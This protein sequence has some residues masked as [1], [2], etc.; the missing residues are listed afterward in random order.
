MDDSRGSRVAEIRG[1]PNAGTMVLPGE[2]DPRVPGAAIESAWSKLVPALSLIAP[3][4]P[5]E[6]GY[7]IFWTGLGDTG[8]RDFPCVRGAHLIVGR[9]ALADVVLAGDAE[10]SLRHL[11]V[12]PAQASGGGAALRL[13]D[14]QASL[15]MFLDDDTPQRSL[16]AEG[17]FAVRVGRYVLGGFPIGP[18]Q[19]HP[20]ADLPR[21]DRV[22]GI[23][24]ARPGL[25][26]GGVPRQAPERRAREPMPGEGGPYR[27]AAHRSRSVITMMPRPITM[28]ES[29]GSAHDD[30]VAL[31]G[32]AR[33][34]ERVRIPLRAAD[35]RAGV[36]VGRADKCTDRGLRPL[37]TIRVSRV[38]AV[39]IDVEGR[40]MLYDCASTNGTWASGRRVRSIELGATPAD[41]GPLVQLAGPDGI[42]LRWTPIRAGAR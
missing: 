25:C 6:I 33:D 14:L 2:T 19:G 7:R 32:A 41:E 5:D 18:G 26:S 12:V 27:D 23:L 17:P 3:Q 36:L 9:H 30:A 42:E 29:V 28:V 13:V 37:L 1:A 24:D 8:F 31:L 20:P 11:L 21:P 22:D 38:H 34:G 39:V 10:L 40:T 16:H 15:P 35:L 4:S